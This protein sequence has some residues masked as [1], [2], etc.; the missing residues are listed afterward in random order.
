MAHVIVR[1]WGGEGGVMGGG[2]GG[3]GGGGLKASPSTMMEEC[4]LQCVDAGG[5][6]VNHRVLL[7]VSCR[8]LAVYTDN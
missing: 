2:G 5:G 7:V 8:A 1:L 6:Y 3:G 4:C